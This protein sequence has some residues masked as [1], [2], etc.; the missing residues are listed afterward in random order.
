MA[1]STWFSE[2]FG[3]IE[4]SADAVRKQLSLE[5]ETLLSKASR[6]TFTLGRF[7]TPSLKEIRSAA[8]AKLR[9]RAGAAAGLHGA[10]GPTLC[11]VLGDAA[12]FHRSSENRLS[13]FQVASQFNCLEFVGP[14]VT[15]EEG[16]TG[17]VHDKTQGPCCAIACGPATV[18]RN[19]FVP[20]RDA[21]GRVV[22]TGQ[23]AR[24]QIENLRDLAEA[25]DGF[26]S[27]RG[28][29]FPRV[30]GGYTLA[31]DAQLRELNRQL[32]SLGEAELDELAGMLRIGVQEDTQVTSH[33]WGRHRLRDRSQR[34]TQIF[35]SACSVSYSRN[36]SPALWKPLASL[37]LKATYEAT[38]WAAVLNAIRHGG[39]AGSRRVFLTAV[40][41]GV[42]G[43][44]MEWVAAA[45]R[46]AM[47]QIQA[48]GIVLDVQIIGYGAVDPVLKSLAAES[49]VTTTRHADETAAE[50]RKK[51]S[52]NVDRDGANL[53]ASRKRKIAPAAHAESIARAVPERTPE[54]PTPAPAK[55]HRIPEPGAKPNVLEMLLR[56]KRGTRKNV[57]RH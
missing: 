4:G 44:S 20:V 36:S 47:Q 6:E 51:P 32:T 46:G 16:I 57:A 7:S 34:V 48:R 18:Y 55:R 33:S 12:E 30:E 24:Q 14:S 22:S 19:Y 31:S 27:A 3:F 41:G 42:F 15:P 54:K 43:N 28:G 23:S 56:T 45:I 49:F 17:Y 11:N 21:G 5:G 35:S 13:T 37:V 10:G 29:I 1:R 52:R 8:L 39:A 25:M 2:L 9:C 26:S 38:L 53:V 50:K 40:G